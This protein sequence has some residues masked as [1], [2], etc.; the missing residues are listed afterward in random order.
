LAGFYGVRGPTSDDAW[1]RVNLDPKRSAGILTNAGLLSVLAKPN[2]SSPVLRGKFVRERMLCQTPPPPPP[3]IDVTPPDLDPKLTTRE[4]FAQ[5]S[6]DP[7][8]KGC[9]R[10][11][12]PI[13]LAFEHYDGVGR[14]RDQENGLPID[15]SGELV[16]TDVDGKFVGV[17]E[18]GKKLASSARVKDCVVL[19]WF[20]H[21]V[22]RAETE[23]D[24]CSLHTLREKF[25]ASGGNVKQLI[26]DMTQ[27][28]AFLLRNGGKP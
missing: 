18:L 15:A 8:C 11:M 22:G 2:Q 20:R 12:D 28:D 16:E 19:Q 25:R 9:H 17:A 21:S 26:L 23:A 5:H 14:F 4:R 7:M 27:T 13:G 24:T 10:L 6:T 3:N 1:V